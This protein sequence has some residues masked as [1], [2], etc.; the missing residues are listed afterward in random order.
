NKDIDKKSAREDENGSSRESPEKYTLPD[1]RLLVGQRRDLPDLETK[2]QTTH[3]ADGETP[4]DALTSDALGENAN[5][6]QKEMYSRAIRELNGLKEDE[7]PEP[8][9]D[10][11]LPGIDE[12]GDYFFNDES[13][14]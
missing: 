9:T 5:E 2:E 8:G 7:I 6:E 13:R 10:L 11:K 3:T 4:V 12:K 1:F 14:T